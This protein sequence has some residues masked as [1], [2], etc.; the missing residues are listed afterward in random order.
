MLA[1]IRV[2]LGKRMAAMQA[3]E[4]GLNTCCSSP[5]KCGNQPFDVAAGRMLARLYLEDRMEPKR[6]I[7]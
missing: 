4:G 3:L 6:N 1:R 2:G 5:G 7:T